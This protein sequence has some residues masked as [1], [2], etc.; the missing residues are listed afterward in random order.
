MLTPPAIGRLQ[1]RKR[2]LIAGAGGGFDVYGGVPLALALRGARVDVHF[3]N[4]SFANLAE[5]PVEWVEPGLARVTA[6]TPP[7]GYFPEQVLATYLEMLAFP[8]PVWCFNCAGVEPAARA[9]RSLA[10]RLDL[11]AVVLV[12]GGSDALMCG[13]EFGLGTP[14]EDFTSIAAVARLDVPERQL[15]SVGFGV[16][17]YHGVCH[18]QVLR[19]IAELTRTGGYLGALSLHTESPEVRA[20]LALVAFAHERTPHR[21]SI[22]CGSIA[23]AVRGHFGD[24]HTTVRTAGSALFINPLMSLYWFFDLPKL[25]ARVRFLSALDGTESWGDVSRVIDTFRRGVT[26]R[27]WE[28]IPI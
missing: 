24:H 27:E 12:D 2:V 1:T 9:Y 21:P 3:A 11:D 17:A 5:L 16:D 25:A 13:D 6:R 14:V 7:A 26:R 8:S 19:A 15:L 4:M 22:V 10:E 23:S 28:T 20:F 18:A